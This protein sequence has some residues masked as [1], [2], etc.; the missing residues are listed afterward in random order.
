MSKAGIAKAKSI[1][2]GNWTGAFTKPAPHL[3][4]HQWNWDSGFIALGYSH[5]DIDK[6]QA[7]L[8]HLFEG[9]W[10]NGM[11]PQI[12]FKKEEGGSKYF[13]GPD[14]WK[15]GSAEAAPNVASTSGITM[16]AV[17]GFILWHIF[18]NVTDKGAMIPFMKEMFPNIKRLHQYLYQYRDPKNEGLPYIRHPWSSG[19]DNSPVWD[20]VLSAID[21]K[22]FDLPTYERKDLQNKKAASHRPTDDDYDRYVYLVD[23]FRRHNYDEAALQEQCPFQVQDPLF[24]G[25]LNYSNEC[26]I[27]IAEVIGEDPAP[28]ENWYYSTN[29]GLNSKLWNRDSGRYDAYDLFNETVLENFSCNSYI[30][31]LCGAPE[32]FESQALV[33]N[34]FDLKIKNTDHYLC[35]SFDLDQPGSNPEKYWRGPV[36]ININWMLYLGLLRYDF[37]KEAEI[38]RDNSI[39]LIDKFGFHEYFDARKNIQENGYG[40]DNFSWSAALYLELKNS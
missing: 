38:L 19:T 7:E 18:T 33:D 10:K 27:K 29:Q 9:Q 14:F 11:L 3:Y 6:A 13:P 37:H 26:M 23:L 24:I 25:I 4:P 30:P 15:T 20:R 5:F 36:W 28:F 39:E 35:P 12:R 1:L 8:R 16:P 21:I 40:T 22:K 34:L 2:K 17:H 31:L 32:A